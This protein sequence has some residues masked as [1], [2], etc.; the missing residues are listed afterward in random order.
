MGFFKKLFKSSSKKEEP[1]PDNTRL[2][3][4]IE[5]YIS[6]KE[7]ESYKKVVLELEVGNSYLLI[8]SENDWAEKFPKWSPSPPGLKFK[9]TIRFVDGLKSIMAFTSEHALFEWAKEPAKYVSF[10][11]KFVLELCELNGI[12]R[13]VIDDKLRTMIILGK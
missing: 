8:P 4:L 5:Q 13:I 10:R 1:E 9:L 7:Y 3:E 6:D 2:F 12:D 11:S